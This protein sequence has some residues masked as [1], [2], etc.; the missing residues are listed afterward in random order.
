M[1]IVAQYVVDKLTGSV[2]VMGGRG[3]EKRN[4][5][6]RIITDRELGARNRRRIKKT[7]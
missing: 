4:S 3:S 5:G 1:L 7:P 6:V 2:I